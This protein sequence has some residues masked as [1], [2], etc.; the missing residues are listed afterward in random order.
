[1]SG[2]VQKPGITCS[3]SGLP[4]HVQAS[5][6]LTSHNVPLYVVET[7]AQVVKLCELLANVISD[8]KGRIERRQAQTYEEHLV[9]I[10]AH[11]E[12]SLPAAWCQ[13]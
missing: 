9:S 13:D 11:T 5:I 12:C 4:S 3:L 8:T 7:A 1:V 6:S 2:E 10:M